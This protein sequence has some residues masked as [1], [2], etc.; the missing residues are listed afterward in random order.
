MDGR[1]LVLMINLIGILHLILRQERHR[2]IGLF[3]LKL[4]GLLTGA[5]E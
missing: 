4:I 5:P 1:V 3:V 2:P